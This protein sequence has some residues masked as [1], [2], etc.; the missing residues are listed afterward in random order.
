MRL[1]W[2]TYDA[3]CLDDRASVDGRISY[4]LE[5]TGLEEVVIYS[6][7]YLCHHGDLAKGWLTE[8]SGFDFR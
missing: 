8:E 1:L 2:G 6:C 3:P 4:E 7:V 5:V